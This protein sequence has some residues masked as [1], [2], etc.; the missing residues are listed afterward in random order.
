[1]GP[2]TTALG[3]ETTITLQRRTHTSM[4]QRAQDVRSEKV[5]DRR[6]SFRHA[7]PRLV[8]NLCVIY[9]FVS[10]CMSRSRVEASADA[11]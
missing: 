8:G 6:H 5:C 3:V 4:R 1:M 2:A 10:L 9:A 7:E 11:T